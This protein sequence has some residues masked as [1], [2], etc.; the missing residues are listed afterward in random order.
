MDNLSGAKYFLATQSDDYYTN[1]LVNS[2]RIS[3]IV[4]LK[5]LSFI[6]HAQV[7]TIIAT[8]GVIINIIGLPL[9]ILAVNSKITET[10]NSKTKSISIA[11]AIAV[12][13]VLNMDFLHNIE[14]NGFFINP[15]SQGATTSN[16]AILIFL[17]GIITENKNI[18]KSLLILSLLLHV[19]S[20]IY[21]LLLFA[22]VSDKKRWKFSR[23][24]AP[25]FWSACFAIAGIAVIAFLKIVQVNGV[26]WEYYVENRAPN[27]FV[28]STS[29]PRA[30]TVILWSLLGI[31]ILFKSIFMSKKYAAIYLG[32]VTVSIFFFSYHF[33]A[34][35]FAIGFLCLALGI[36]LRVIAIA[37]ITLL[38]LFFLQHFPIDSISIAASMLVP[39]TRYV[40]IVT[41]FLFVNLLLGIDKKINFN[42]SSKF[43]LTSTS[44]PPKTLIVFLLVST[45]ACTVLSSVS[46]IKNF[47]YLRS[48]VSSFDFKNEIA[49][50]EL[51]FLDVSSQGWREFGNYSIFVDDYP[52]WGNLNEYRT[53]SILRFKLIS[54][55]QEGNLN[56]EELQEIQEES[57]FREE[58]MLVTSK[59]YAHNLRNLSCLYRYEF[60]LCDLGEKN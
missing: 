20:F 14:V 46:A 5:I 16:L 9:F 15:F 11:P 39:A 57:R 52:F 2:P 23:D 32:I 43:T 26:G 12:I 24:Q 6:F 33:Y 54:L 18:K 59:K 7:E 31:A 53:R 56:S 4:I 10:Q 58:I 44:K 36:Q 27:H 34:L 40:S 25:V 45:F 50:K 29:T 48:K 38:F 21:L 19:S 28:I 37:T 42:P 47:T 30:L 8:L 13:T 22:L 49:K 3:T 35:P 41:L 51:I 17:S 55:V 1:S 60:L